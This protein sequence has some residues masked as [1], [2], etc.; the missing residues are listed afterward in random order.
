[1][2]QQRRNNLL[3][4]LVG[5]KLVE[6][7]KERGYSQQIVYIHTGIDM[8]MVESGK[9]NITFS[10]LLELCSYYKVSLYEF[11]KGMPNP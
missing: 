6:L 1:M 8:D 4:E 10:T 11:F 9:Y 5:K 2:G 7:R 3:L